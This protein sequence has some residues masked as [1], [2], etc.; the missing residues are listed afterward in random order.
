M[1][2]D[3]CDQVLSNDSTFCNKC[4]HKVSNDSIEITTSELSAA[5]SNDTEQLPV[6]KKSKKK[7]LIVS[8]VIIL[9]LSVGGGSYWYYKDSEK[10]EHARLH[11]EYQKNMSEAALRIIAFSSIS[12][13][14]TDLY[15]TVWSKAIDADFGVEVNG[16]MAYNFND[17]IKLQIEHLEEKGVL[18]SLNENTE[19]VDALMKKLSA[20]PTD[21]Q[22]AYNVLVEL[23]GNYTQYADQANSPSGSLIEFNKKT[24][25]LSSEI[26]KNYNQFKILLPELDETKIGDYI[27]TQDV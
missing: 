2:C 3:N 5:V 7:P 27:D 25:N 12:E 13:Q 9:L 26:L 8:L 11:S 20:P 17:A 1:H 4:G 18:S 23:Y 24:N 19:S 22:N 16:K 21:F 6:I 15:S 14:I 10:K